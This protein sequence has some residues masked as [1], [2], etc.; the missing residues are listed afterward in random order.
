M[1]EWRHFFSGGGR[2]VGAGQIRWLDDAADHF[3]FHR[4]RRN[5]H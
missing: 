2:C 3:E 5:H 1:L 4:R